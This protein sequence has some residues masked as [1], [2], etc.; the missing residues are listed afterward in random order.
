MKLIFGFLLFVAIVAITGG[1]YLIIRK[2]DDK[3]V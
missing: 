1:L 2:E 3:E